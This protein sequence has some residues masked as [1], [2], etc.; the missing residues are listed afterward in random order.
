[1]N[2]TFLGTGEAFDP[3]LPNTSV[4]IEE[5]NK[6]LLVDCGFSVPPRFWRTVH[7]PD[8]LDA[9]YLTHLHAD[10]FFGLPALLVRLHEDHRT[11]P[12]TLLTQPGRFG[13]VMQVAERA[14][15]G[16]LARMRYELRSADAPA[17]GAGT[18]EGIGVRTAQTVHGEDNFAVRF[19]F[20]SGKSVM[21]SGDGEIT[22]DSREL[23]RGCSLVIHEAYRI[24]AHTPGHS[25]VSEVL[26][27]AA[28]DPP[29]GL[30]ALV[31]TCR[32]ER[33]LLSGTVTGQC[34]IPAP[35]TL[36]SV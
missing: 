28:L 7:D 32:T 1:M 29:P 26:E 21:V 11:R 36:I 27:A 4:L 33:D 31:H 34:V 12:L 13:S 25:S 20:P 30:V 6:T 2:I 17:G 3:H 16:L 35:G 9:V 22:P 19:D 15:P 10:H 8:K 24:K 18:W 14:Y 23:L 5:D